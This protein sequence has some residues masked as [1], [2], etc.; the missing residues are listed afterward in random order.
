MHVAPAALHRYILLWSDRIGNGRALE[1]RADI[2]APELL[3]LFIVVGDD[4]A[5]LERGEHNAASRRGDARANLDVGHGLCH[6]LVADRVIGADGAVVE[7]AGVAPLLV[8][9]PIESAV[10]ALEGGGGAIL[11]EAAFGADPIGDVL[12]RIIGGG[13]IRNAAMPGR[14]RA[15]HRIAAQRAAVVAIER[16]VEAVAGEMA[17]H[18]AHL[19]VDIDVVEQMDADLVIV[20]GIVGQILVIPDELAGIDI[21]RDHGVGIEVVAGARLRIVLWHRV[22]GAPDGETS[23]GIVGA[24]L[25]QAAASRLPG[26][27]LVLPGLAARI[28]G[29]GDGIPTPQLLAGAGVEPGKPTAGRIAGAI[30]DE[31]LAVD[32]Q[33]RGIELLAAAE[34]V[35]RGDLFVPDDLA[36]VAVDGDDAAVRQVGD[37]KVFPQGDAAGARDVALMLDAGIGDPD[38]LA[39]IGIAG[40]DLID[41]APAVH[42][43]HES[44]VD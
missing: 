8:P 18:L 44:V 3:E 16:I 5:V 6:D 30:G 15:F 19:A 23:G 32:R 12:H 33:R 11:A 42:G 2:E 35:D 38:E 14:A 34:L 31:H 39:M 10:R 28:A 43:V 21:E 9:H 1:R 4:P 17:E 25:P 41:R 37:D 20:P 22:A 26:T 7:I 13:L 24:G 29:L 27:G 36:A 40:I